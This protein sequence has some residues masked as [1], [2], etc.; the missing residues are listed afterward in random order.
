VSGALKR[1]IIAAA[2]HRGRI[3]AEHTPTHSWQKAD[4]IVIGRVSLAS[5]RMDGC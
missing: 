2:F 3:K 1:P 4:L 5:D